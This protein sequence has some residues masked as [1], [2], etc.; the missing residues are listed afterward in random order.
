VVSACPRAR[1]EDLLIEQLGNELLVYDERRDMAT[2]MNHTAAVVWRNSDGRRTIADLVELLRAEVGEVADED[3]VMI[4]LDYLE[5]QDLLESGYDSREL[6]AIRLS[7]RR[8]IERAGLAGTAAIVLPVVQS[9]VAPTPAAAASPPGG[10][11]G[12]Q[13]PQGVQGMQGPQGVQGIQGVQGLL[14]SQGPQG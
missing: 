14:G 2:R 7:R 8:F 6:A 10:S 4:T 3:L 11:Q 13:G 9:I 1:S 12:S 5:E